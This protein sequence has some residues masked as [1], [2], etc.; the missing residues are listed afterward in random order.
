MI[1]INLLPPEELK[2]IKFRQR[3]I[4]IIPFLIIIFSLLFIVWIGFII[5]I[6]HLKSNVYNN[7]AKVQSVAPRKTQVDTIWNQLHNE[8]L[9]K[10]KHIETFIIRPLDWA[11]ILNI[12]SDFS[13]QGIWLNSLDLEKKDNVWLLT[14][15]GFAKPVTTR[16]MI[17]DIGNY[18]TNVKEHIEA[19]VLKRVTQS[20]DLNDF[21]EV[22][23]TTK[24][25]KADNIELTEFITTFKIA[26]L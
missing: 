22:T 2:S 20:E 9:V 17:K 12:I 19:S 6:T 5:S 3:K 4:P 23:T 13:S 8:L 26:L 25:K 21:I 11:H 24:R 14:F 18:V 10:K 1:H 16:S 15:Q 7:Y